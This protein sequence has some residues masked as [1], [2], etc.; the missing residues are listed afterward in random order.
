MDTETIIV[1]FVLPSLAVAAGIA[2]SVYDYII[3]PGKGF[4]EGLRDWITD[5]EFSDW[6]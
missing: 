2:Y 5:D 1:L 6:W 3:K 4:L